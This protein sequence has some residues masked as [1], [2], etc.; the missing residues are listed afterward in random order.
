MSETK[1]CHV[2]GAPVSEGSEQHCILVEV[3]PLPSRVFRG[4][5]MGKLDRATRKIDAQCRTIAKQREALAEM[6]RQ[7][8]NMRTALFKANLQLERRGG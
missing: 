4:D 7:H 1:L 3:I 6:T 2:C 5:P 8:D